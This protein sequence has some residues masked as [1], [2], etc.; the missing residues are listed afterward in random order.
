MAE[1]LQ[2]SHEIASEAPRK[3]GSAG[4][5]VRGERF[6]LTGEQSVDLGDLGA[7]AFELSGEVMVSPSLSMLTL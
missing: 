2:T 3:F 7:Q 4:C 6:P 1:P 5:G